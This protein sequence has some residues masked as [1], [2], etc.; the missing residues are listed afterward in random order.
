MTLPII[1]SG[2][3]S[4]NSNNVILNQAPPP[5]SIPHNNA[6]NKSNPSIATSNRKPSQH[7]LP[8]KPSSVS[9]QPVIPTTIVQQA[10]KP[11]PVPTPP[12]EKKPDILLSLTSTYT[13][14]LEQSLAN[15]EHDVIKTE[16]LPNINAGMNQIPILLPNTNSN[17]N[18]NIN[19]IINPNPLNTLPILQPAVSLEIKPPIMMSNNVMP[20]NS[21]MHAIHGSLEHDL[22]ILPPNT[23]ITSN[24]IHTTNNGFALKHE[25]EMTSNNNGMATMAGITMNMNIPSLFDPLPQINNVTIKKEPQQP[26]QQQHPQQQ[27]IPHQPLLHPKPIEELTEPIPQISLAEK[28]LTPPDQKSQSFN[29]KPKAEQNIKNAS[30]WSSLAQSSNSPQNPTAAVGNVSAVSTVSNSRQQ[31]MDSFKAFQKQAKEKADREKQRLENLEL[32]RQQKEQAEKER[33]RVENEKRREK[34][35]E[36]ALEKARYLLLMCL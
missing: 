3:H 13:D 22:S 2:V 23:N 36:D 16:P 5:V 29:F 28:K 19:P 32:K 25:Y 14:P 24:L 8:E 31:V 7:I 33:L 21:L 11:V 6:I 15:L 9:I 12:P 1:A 26:Q 34:E 35:E 18:L 4:E 10:V 27:Q 20:V 17:P 30:S